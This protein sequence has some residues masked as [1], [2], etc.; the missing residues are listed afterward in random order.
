MAP[1]A[2]P[3]ALKIVEGRSPGRD[4]GGRE[5]AAD[6]GFARLP[7]D[8]PAFLPGDALDLGEQVVPELQRL[9]LT[10]PLDQPALTALCLAWGRLC[11][12]QRVLAVEGMTISTP[13]GLGRHPMVIVAELASKE[14]RAWC[15]EFGLSPSSEGRLSPLVAKPEGSNP[16]D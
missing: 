16:F 12:A 14:L 5:V 4:S 3:R 7:P 13:R 8:A 9:H 1:K 2:R 6:P 11:D 10:K 15:A